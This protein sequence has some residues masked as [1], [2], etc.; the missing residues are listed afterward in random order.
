MCNN[1]INYTKE[2][3][4]IIDYAKQNGCSNIMDLIWI[5]YYQRKLLNKIFDNYYKYNNIK[6]ELNM[7]HKRHTH[8]LDIYS[9][10]L[11]ES[12]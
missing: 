6:S 11:I 1:L 5:A 7:I 10:H 2:I 8:V 9:N 3:P 4:K 12:N